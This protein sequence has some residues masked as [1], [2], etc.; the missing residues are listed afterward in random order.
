MRRTFRSLASHNFRLW[1]FTGLVSNVGAWMQ[2][3]AQSWVVLTEL[4]ANDAVA[5]GVTMALQL[6][7]QIVLVPITGLLADRVDRRKLLLATQVALTVLTLGI[8]LL[9]AS[10]RAE[11]WH[12]LVFALIFGVIT[13]VDQPA[14]NT[15]VSDLVGERDIPNAVALNLASHHAA[16]LV[17]PATAGI[18]IATLGSG[19]V[20]VLNA[21][22]FLPL[23][24]GLALMRRNELVTVVRQERRRGDAFAGFRY[25]GR[26]PDLGVLLAMAF[27]LGIIGMNFQLF[28]ATMAVEFGAGPGEFGL[29]TSVMAI[30]SLVGALLSAGR[31][32]A[33]LRVVLLAGAAMGALCLLAAFMPTFWTFAIT[34]IFIGL[35]GVTT[36]TT[37]NGYAQVATRPALRGRV[38]SIH[39]A[40]LAAGTP[41]GAPLIGWVAN[42]FGARW[43]LGSAFLLSV[44]ACAVGLGWYALRRRPARS[45]LRRTAPGA[46]PL[47]GPEVS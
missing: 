24:A 32:R 15:I 12:F 17:G 43:A 39:M 26:R 35:A 7:P 8:G 4:T 47:P 30:G 27:L 16:R 44:A 3:T 45:T 46:D 23:I 28:A 1:F 37:A 42:E 41:V 20:F 21:V 18:V 6:A 33:R 29:L 14:R 38:M 22:T 25:I 36:F 11:L 10:G 2:A 5:V 13:A 40:V 9:L 31:E 34:T 19:W